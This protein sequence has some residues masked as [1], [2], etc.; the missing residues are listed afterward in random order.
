MSESTVDRQHEEKLDEQKKVTTSEGG[1]GASITPRTPEQEQAAIGAGVPAASELALADINPVNAHLFKEN[2]WQD[3]FARLRAEDP[4][5]L[6]E[7][8]SAGRYWSLTR[9]ED[10]KKVDAD[11]QSF[12]SAHGISLGF[13]VGMEVPNSPFSGNSPFI[14]QDPPSHDDQ[15]KTVTGVVAP[16][17][18]ALLE[19]LIRERTCAV[20]D[21]L[22]VDETFDWVDTVSIELTTM[23]LATL[24][25][26]PFE[27]RR[28]LTRWSDIVF[29][30]PEPGGIVETQA[31]KQEEFMEC[32]SYFG[33][34]W[35]ER[36]EKPG[37]D[38]VSMLAH[39]ETTRH[40]SA[41][42]HLGNLLLLI[43]GGNDTT[44]NTMSGSVY[45]LNKFPDQYDKLTANPALIPN[46]VAEVIRWQTP[47]SYMRRTAT[48]DV[49]LKGREIKKDDQ[50]LMWYVSGNRDEDVFENADMLDIERRNARQHLSFGFGIHRCMGNRLAELQLRILWEEILPRFD[51]IEVVGEPQ[52]TF[53]S[54][55][56]GYTYLPVKIRGRKA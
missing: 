7:I 19:P 42:E 48:R 24:F 52:R 44:R 3:H 37:N 36:R 20:L 23:M 22:P 29:A 40:M 15:R 47:L 18:L 32:I 27:D 35:E 38:L 51:R 30:I 26:F 16:R 55:V 54:F 53:S 10:I 5:H 56:K 49:T 17:N 45:S 28:K 14:S 2:R 33:R 41:A 8:E 39:G 12:S 11:W 9:Y 21:S 34:L 1:P 6:N 25:D 43:V 46:M 31:Q 4:I 50:L 13:K